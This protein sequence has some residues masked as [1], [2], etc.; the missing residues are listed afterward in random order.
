MARCKLDILRSVA[1]RFPATVVE[2]LCVVDWRTLKATPKGFSWVMTRPVFRLG[3]FSETR[4]SSGVGPGGVRKFTGR[5]G[6]GRVGSGQ[7]VFKSHGSGLGHPDTIRLVWYG[8]VYRE[9]I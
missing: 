2:V 4:G 3:I 6:S 1:A 9:G 5:V 7:E 8:M